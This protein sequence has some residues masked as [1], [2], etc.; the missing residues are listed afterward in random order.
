MA[1]VQGGFPVF[2]FAQDDETSA[3]NAAL[4][5]QLVGRHAALVVAGLQVAGALELPTIA[6]HPAVQPILMVQG[7]YRLA[8]ALA[9]AR[10]LD[11]DHPP[12]LRKVTET[13]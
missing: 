2:L 3:S 1:L 8:E 11:P 4:A 10:G 9:R 6:A 12:H 7:F 5:A 13:V